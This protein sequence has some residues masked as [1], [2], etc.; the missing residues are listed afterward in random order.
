MGMNGEDIVFS[1]A[2]QDCIPYS[3]ECKN[4]ERLQLW[5]AIAQAEENS[6]ARTPVLVIKRNQTGSYAVLPLDAFMS[7]IKED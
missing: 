1:P 4:Q 7:L 5:S 2:A 6:G 3:F